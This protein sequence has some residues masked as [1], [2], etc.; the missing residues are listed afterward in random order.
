[1]YV[2]L[3]S[4]RFQRGRM[5]DSPCF[6]RQRDLQD[7]GTE[8][9]WAQSTGGHRVPVTSLL[10]PTRDLISDGETASAIALYIPDFG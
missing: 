7:V 2:D 5:K 8:V 9:R 10:S 6:L 4:D 1:M 3:R